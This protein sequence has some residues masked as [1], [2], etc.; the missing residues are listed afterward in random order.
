MHYSLQKLLSQIKVHILWSSG[1]KTSKR[2]S[3]CT[4]SDS[5][6][7]CMTWHPRHLSLSTVVSHVLYLSCA[8]Q[9]THDT[10]TTQAYSS[11]ACHVHALYVHHI[12]DIVCAI[13]THPRTTTHPTDGP[14]QAVSSLSPT[15]IWRPSGWCVPSKF[16]RSPKHSTFLTASRWIQS[17][18]FGLK[19]STF[20]GHNNNGDM[21]DMFL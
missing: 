13:F 1:G 9:L 20:I 15:E 7:G 3:V 11:P 17:S 8:I 6:P 16:S 19:L 5:L 10:T 21:L 18:H 14:E 2:K 12:G 4:H